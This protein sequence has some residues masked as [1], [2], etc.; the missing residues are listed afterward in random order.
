MQFDIG[1]AV[2]RSMKATGPLLASL[3]CLL[4]AGCSDTRSFPCGDFEPNITPDGSEIIYRRSFCEATG[5]LTT[6][7]TGMRLIAYDVG[8]R[9][10]TPLPTTDSSRF[11]VSDDGAVIV[12]QADG[13]TLGIYDRA[14]GQVNRVDVANL[15]R[16]FLFPS[17]PVIS[18]DAKIIAFTILLGDN[19][20]AVFIYDRATDQIERATTVFRAVRPSLSA[21]GR[22]LAFQTDT[23][24]DG[25]GTPAIHAL[26]RSVGETGLVS[27]NSAGEAADDSSFEPVISGDGRFVVFRSAATN[28]V[29]SLARPGS[30]EVYL[31]DRQ[32]G[33]TT[34]ISRSQSSGEPSGTRAWLG[35][36]PH[37]ISADGRFIV[38]ESDS[39]TIVP[40]GDETPTPVHS[41]YLYDRLA[42]SSTRVS[43]NSSGEP[44]NRF[45]VTPSVS[46]DG[47][48]VAFSTN[49]NNLAPDDLDFDDDVYIYDIEAGETR[50]VS[51]P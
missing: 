38:Y 41:L 25:A 27:V 30:A 29:A 28:L 6:R 18:G 20:E 24:L 34:L 36:P 40:V 26:D 31:H 37:A 19:G 49:S 2:Q 1:R 44:A 14:S 35:Q 13:T 4:L 23:D 22:F 12:Y 46:D 33:V 51:E 48:F 16:G 8:Q 42:D 9:T 3:C 50:R 5:M 32:A 15:G 39:N 43:V 47:R 7:V 11:D 10:A 17:A 21:D 45:S